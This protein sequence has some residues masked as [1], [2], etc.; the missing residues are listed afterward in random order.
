MPTQAYSHISYAV[1]RAQDTVRIPL[2]YQATKGDLISYAVK[3][4]QDTIRIPGLQ[5]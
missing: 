1:K 3:R 4:A 5:R 2:G